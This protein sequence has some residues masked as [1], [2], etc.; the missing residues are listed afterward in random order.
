MGRHKYSSSLELLS[1]L[2]NSL[3]KWM[4]LDDDS[5][6]SEFNK[7]RNR[8]YQVIWNLEKDGLIEKSKNGKNV[9][10]AIT[11]KGRSLLKKIIN[12]KHKLLSPDVYKNNLSKSDS[13][14]IVAFDIPE[15]LRSRRSQIRKVLKS[16]DF[17]MIQKSVWIGK[18][19][20]PDDFIRDLKDLNLLVYID[21]FSINKSGSLKSV[22]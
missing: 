10:V 9:L 15:K 4:G 19:K 12:D 8:Y 3:D 14:I 7:N 13:V 17:R 5:L 1:V 21:I 16:L 2:T 6:S 20:I 22:L 11:N 18:N